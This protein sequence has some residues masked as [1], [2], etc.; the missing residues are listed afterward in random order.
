MAYLLERLMTDEEG[1]T[2]V[3]YSLMVALIA[4]VAAAAVTTLGASIG[5]QLTAVS[6]AI[7][8]P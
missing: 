8:G 6:S 5:T 1:A 2:M 7:G 4:G 3:E